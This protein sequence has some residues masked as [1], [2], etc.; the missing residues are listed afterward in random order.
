MERRRVAQAFWHFSNK[1]P[2]GWFGHHLGLTLPQLGGKVDIRHVDKERSVVACTVPK[3]LCNADGRLCL[4]SAVALFD[5]ISTFA[6]VVPWDRD[7]RPGASV[8]LSAQAYR[9]LDVGAGDQVIFESAPVKM[10]KTLAFVDTQIKDVNGT[11]LAFARHIKFQPMGLAFSLATMPLLRP[12]S[13]TAFERYLSTLK[14]HTLEQATCK[15]RV[16]PVERW[17][18]DGAKSEGYV[19]CTSELGNPIGAMHGGA[20]VMMATQIA[21]RALNQQVHTP[22]APLPI[23]VRVHAV[24]VCMC[25]SF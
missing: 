21:R 7:W 15:D 9:P 6:G 23:K 19:S 24:Y 11:L 16:F 22:S 3:W 10:G 25:P 12:L 17:T 2:H 20:Q 4:S 1:S 5:E 14:E 13:L 18:Q 8:Q